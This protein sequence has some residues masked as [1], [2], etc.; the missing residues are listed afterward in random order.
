[1][2]F[3]CPRCKRPLKAKLKTEHQRV[4][5]PTCGLAMRLP[6]CLPAALLRLYERSRN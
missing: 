2:T 4:R 3:S 1:M 6:S 5:C